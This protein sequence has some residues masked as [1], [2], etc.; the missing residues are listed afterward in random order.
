MIMAN[1]PEPISYI[2]LNDGLD[3][4]PINAVSIEGKLMSDFQE[5]GKIV[6]TISASSTDEQIPSTKCIYEI[7]YRP[8]QS[9]QTLNNTWDGNTIWNGNTIWQ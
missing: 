2:K 7:I 9:Q 1:T 8:V 4:H 3:P 5:A 6:Q